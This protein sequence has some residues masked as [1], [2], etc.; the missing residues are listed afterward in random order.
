M[1]NSKK[2]FILRDSKG[3]THQNFFKKISGGFTLIE[4][5]VVVAIIGILASV[6]LASLNTA[7]TKGAD[8]AIKANLANIRASAAMY[9][10]TYGAYITGSAVGCTVTKDGNVAGAFCTLGLMGDTQFLAGLK[11]AANASGTILNVNISLGGA[12]TWAAGVA[13]KTTTAP[14]FWCV[15]SNGASLGT[16]LILN[17]GTFFCP[18]S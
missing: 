3:F 15:D 13:L 9:Y 10:D 14:T 12:G 6:V 17:T 2:V 1:K 18:T 11:A 5:L 16:A 4:L 8:A 7:R